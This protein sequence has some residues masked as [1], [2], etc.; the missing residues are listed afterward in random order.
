[1]AIQWVSYSNTA[2]IQGEK[3]PLPEPAP[4]VGQYTPWLPTQAFAQAVSFY[5][6]TVPRL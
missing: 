5:G 1:M 6:T 3:L 4:G 2:V